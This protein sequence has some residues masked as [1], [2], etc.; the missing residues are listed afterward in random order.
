MHMMNTPRPMGQPLTFEHLVQI[1]DASD[2]RVTALT[3]DQL[4]QGLMLRATQPETFIPWLEDSVID[5]DMVQGLTRS[6]NFGSYQIHDEVTFV[7]HE[8]VEYQSHDAET[9]AEF[10]LRMRIEE[11]QPEALFVRFIY[12]A[13]SV[14]HH[15]DSPLGYAMKEAYR[16]NDDDLVMRIR[17]LAESGILDGSMLF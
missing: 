17:L 1:N 2:T 13:H 4:W 11:P 10:L 9:G 5:G 3:R 15:A 8:Q 16:F 6:L 14:D 12:Q 7:P